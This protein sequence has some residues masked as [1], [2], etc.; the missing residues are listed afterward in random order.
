[1]SAY[2]IVIAST[3]SGKVAEI[4][5]LLN[6]FKEL[7]FHTKSLGEYS[8]PEPDEPY[9]SFME[10]AIHKAKYY[11]ARTQ[12]ATFSEDSGVCIEGLNGFPGVRTKEFAEEAGGMDKAFKQLEYLLRDTSNYKASFKCASVLY[13]PKEDLLFT[14]EDQDKGSLT[15]PPRGN[16]GFAFDPIFIPNGYDKTFAELG[17][18]MKNQI[19]HRAKA[20]KGVVEKLHEFLLKKGEDLPGNH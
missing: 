13:L 9:N 11:A 4:T 3:N 20:I 15:F 1:M 19:S 17:M 16:M 10:N 7:N 6:S 2:K 5:A 14:Y 18:D 12:E 8:I